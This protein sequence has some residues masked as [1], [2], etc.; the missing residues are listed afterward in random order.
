MITF[1]EKNDSFIYEKYILNCLNIEYISISLS[2]E[3]FLNK[4][5]NKDLDNVFI[6]EEYIEIA[7]KYFSSKKRVDFFKLKNGE[8]VL[9]DSMYE[10]FKKFLKVEKIDLNQKR[11][12]LLGS[13][14]IA[15]SI[16]YAMR[17]LFDPSIYVATITENYFN[18]KTG[19]RKIKKIEIANMQTANFIINTSPMGIRN[20]EN[21]CMLEDKNMISA[22]M[23]ADIITQPFKT[24]LLMKYELRGSKVFTGTLIKCY[25]I[26][27][28]LN[29]MDYEDVDNRISLVYNKIVD[30]F[31]NTKYEE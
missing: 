14:D 9:Y 28:L 6:D 8:Y 24:T 5:S 26:F 29:I 27:S 22:F 18:L 2:D 30:K 11:V 12:L 13:N 23:V 1:I 17:D 31:K 21:T 3:E 4:L 16:Y 20:A 19:D 7:K 25:T 10:G 15:Q